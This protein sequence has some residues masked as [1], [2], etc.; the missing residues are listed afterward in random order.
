MSKEKYYP[1]HPFIEKIIA[2]AAKHENI[3][4]DGFAGMGG[5]TSGFEEA[6][7]Y[8]V[9]A[10]INH[11]DKAINTHELNHPNCLHLQE[12][13]RTADISLLIY[14]VERIRKI[15]PNVK[16]HLWLSLECTNF[17]NAKGGM[18]READSRTLA[19]HADRY[20]I[21]LNPDVIWIENVKEFTLWGPMIPKIIQPVNGKN[22]PVYF[23]PDRD[24]ETIF[25]L[26]E[27]AYCPLHIK[28]SKGKIISMGPWM[29]PDAEHKGEDF[30]KWVSLIKSFGYNSSYRL[31]NTANYGVPQ[32]RVRLFMQFTR[33]N[34]PAFYPE[35]TH[36]KTGANGLKKW[37]PIKDC[38]DLTD[39]GTD[40][41]AFKKNKKTGI[42][43]PRIKSKKT[44]ERLMK[45][46]L[47]HVI[48]AGE[49]TFITKYK[50][51]NAKTGINDGKSISDPSVTVETGNRTGLVKVSLVD[52]YF[53]KSIANT[54]EV[55]AGVTGA[56]DGAALN[57]IKLIGEFRSRGESSTIEDTSKAVVSKD[58][59]SLDTIN[60]ISQQNEGDNR[61]FDIDN[62]AHTATGTGGKMN[63]V[64]SAFIDQRYSGGDQNKDIN[65]PSAA[66][67]GVPKNV[68]VNVSRII[69][70][71]QFNNEAHSLDDTAKTVTANRKHYYIVNFQWFNAGTQE[72]TDVSNTII[73]RMDKAP[74][75]L[76]V[77]ETGHL[78]IEIYEHDPP[79]YVAMKKFMAEH[80]IVSIKMR[81]LKETELLLIQDL[82]SDYKLLESSTDNK[83]MI[84]NAVPRR[85]VKLLANAY[86]K[87]I[88]K[89]AA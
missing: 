42:L 2:E 47:K 54:I 76:I 83:K 73:A 53:G 45:G 56:R 74:N 67:T 63:L 44:V 35:V 15:N 3:V 85:M 87:G 78:A 48:K 72:L 70:D 38:L 40:L 19:D 71:T 28:K 14:M 13:F 10:C 69:M 51:N 57:T 84:G 59:Y 81:M 64:T 77:T 18:S 5:V 61:N 27:G 66:I 1:G 86:S 4:I 32:H 6:D 9:I 89:L 23:N 11:W 43:T 21:A 22:V 55:P 30:N 37:N 88:K 7:D 50:G 36:H 58:K 79:H 12:D 41:L 80:G 62:A 8:Y 46:C 82:P 25:H 24:D 34:V 31:M 52:Y 60:F 39:E 65:N 33:K 29:V 20:V 26:Y 16:V 49:P 17:S 68:P 75:Y